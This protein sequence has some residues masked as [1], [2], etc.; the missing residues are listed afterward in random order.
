MVKVDRS[1]SSIHQLSS[2]QQIFLNP[3]LPNFYTTMNGNVEGHSHP[4]FWPHCAKWSTRCGTCARDPR[5]SR[6]WLRGSRIRFP[7]R[8]RSFQKCGQNKRAFWKPAP[9]RT[10]RWVL[11]QKVWEKFHGLVS[12]SM[13]W[14]SRTPL[15]NIF[16]YIFVLTLKLYFSHTFLYW[17]L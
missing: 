17:K 9:L 15:E 5:A 3:N 14:M 2:L 13:A 12:P 7:I 4:L 16:Q 8:A 11:V 6:R 10:P 1:F